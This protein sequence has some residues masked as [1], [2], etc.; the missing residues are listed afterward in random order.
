ME[1]TELKT[2]EVLKRKCLLLII[3]SPKVLD[4]YLFILGWTKSEWSIV[5]SSSFE[6]RTPALL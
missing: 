3:K 2:V 5:L 6:P 4:N 1:F